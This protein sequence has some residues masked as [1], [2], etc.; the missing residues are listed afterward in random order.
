MHYTSSITSIANLIHFPPRPRQ[1]TFI[2][3]LSTFRSPCLTRPA[4]GQA[5]HHQ[6]PPFLIIGS[7]RHVHTSRQI[8]GRL[9]KVQ[10]QKSTMAHLP[11]T[12]SG[13][14]RPAYERTN[15]HLHA[16]ANVRMRKCANVHMGLFHS[17]SSWILYSPVFS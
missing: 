11:F 16:Y 9:S 10:T 15:A 2:S 7:I 12:V 17:S 4:L 5:T 1:L 13:P 6:T 8:P 3:P 14:G